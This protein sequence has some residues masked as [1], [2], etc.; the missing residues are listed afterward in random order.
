MGM[1][2][3]S[4]SLMAKVARLQALTQ[5]I[6]LLRLAQRGLLAFAALFLAHLLTDPS[7][8][9]HREL[10]AQLD[11]AVAPGHRLLGALPREHAKTTLGT[12]ALVLRELCLGADGVSGGK[13]NILLVS[14][15]REE[16]AGKL[17]Q[18][19]NELECNAKLTAAFGAHIRPLR[20]AHGRNV[21]YADHCIILAG[22]QRVGVLGFGGKVRGQL[23][24]G[25]RLDLI[26]LD[27]PEDDASV[28]SPRIREKL[29]HWVDQA[30]L[31]ALDVD[32]GSLVWLGSLLHHDC[33]LAQKMQLEE[34]AEG[35]RIKDETGSLL[36]PSSFIPHPLAGAW[37]TLCLPAISDEGTPLWPERW[38]LAKLDA[39]RQ[40]IGERAFAQEYQNQ[41][42][43]L[44]ELV[45][46]PECFGCYD[47]AG[48]MHHAGEWTLD[49]VPL[50]VAIGVDPAIG[51]Q[52]QHDWFAAVVLGLTRVA[53][54]GWRVP[55]ARGALPLVYVLD[56][57]RFKRPFAQQLSQL[58]ALA[59]RWSPRAIGIE[60]VAY[61]AA[62]AQ[63]AWDA[64]LPVRPVSGA[65]RK[66]ARIE[67]AAVHQ[68][69]ARMLL[70]SAGAWVASFR[71]E[72]AEYPA[73]SHDDQLDALAR[74]LEVGLP[75]IGGAWDVASAGAARDDVKGFV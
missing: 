38:S 64:G 18:I 24:A 10:C 33:V 17:R 74:A 6:Q 27:D 60:A 15:N 32:R 12:V 25:R 52:A 16:A 73:G 72:A 30:L 59:R 47:P 9:Y 67:T 70:P 41:P 57:L 53:D 63:A 71:Q 3:N 20:D 2:M 51:E 49:G 19:V 23:S 31:N 36:P 35:G 61:Q 14:A 68:A 8:A 55:E 50:T 29:R 42:V 4:A 21:A 45:F 43:S 37:R 7:G 5:R 26:V 62:L 69:D 46:K 54:A 28:A 13:R 34:K 65:S 22:G 11:W 40:E 75:L 1:Q 39:R 58:T 56:V 66:F 44:S 48:L